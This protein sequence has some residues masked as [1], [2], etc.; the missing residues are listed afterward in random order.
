MDLIKS[1]FKCRYPFTRKSLTDRHY[2]LD[3]RHN[4]QKPRQKPLYASSLH[5][6]AFRVVFVNPVSSSTNPPK[7]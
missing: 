6:V 3:R 2:E 7:M 4:F 1:I 5:F